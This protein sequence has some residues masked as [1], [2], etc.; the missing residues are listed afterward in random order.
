V[1]IQGLQ[2]PSNQKKGAPPNLHLGTPS[3]SHLYVKRK[4]KTVLY[5]LDSFCMLQTSMSHTKNQI[6]Y[7][8]SGGGG[9]TT[10]SL[11]NNEGLINAH[12]NGESDPPLWIF[13][14]LFVKYSSAT[15]LTAKSDSEES[16]HQ[17]KNS[18]TAFDSFSLATAKIVFFYFYAIFIFLS[19]FYWK[20]AEKVKLFSVNCS[21]FN[22][23]KIL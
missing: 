8:L 23:L 12:I 6:L 4:D 15:V 18:P 19:F 7:P 11:I 10:V 3:L 21:N 9:C 13:R 14:N 5:T 17:Q 1:G 20:F 2:F 22:K 16:C